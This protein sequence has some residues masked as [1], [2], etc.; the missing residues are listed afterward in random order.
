MPP[1]A[2][3]LSWREGVVYIW[4]GTATA[5]ALAAYVQ[6]VNIMPSIGYLN[7]QTMGG[8]YTNHE[9]G[10]YVQFQVGLM[11]SQHWTLFQMFSSG[12]EVNMHF[13]HSSVNGSAGIY[14]Y[15][16]RI[17]TM[18]LQGQEG[19]IFQWAINGHANVWSSYGG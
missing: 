14:L 13:A 1:S 3:A 19:A 4:T 6:N 8:T 7:R 11:A 2:E 18:P 9:T 16:G 15:S 17:D 5:S 12:N 10:R